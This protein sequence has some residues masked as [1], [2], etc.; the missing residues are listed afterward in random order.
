VVDVFEEVEEQIRTERYMALAKRLAPWAIGAGVALVVSLGGV[1]G[2]QTWHNAQA[3]KAGQIYLDAVEA[4]QNQDEGKAASLFGELTHSPLKIYKV[5]GYMDQAGLR[6]QA[7]K[8]QEAAKLYD[9][10]AAL[11]SDPFV[12]DLARLKSALALM[13]T[14]SYKDIEA[15]LTPLIDDKRPLHLSAREALA[16]AKLQAG[17]TAE[18]RADFNALTLSLGAPEGMVQRARVAMDL[19]DSGSA[20]AMAQA[21]KDSQTINPSQFAPAG[22]QPPEG[23]PQ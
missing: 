14:A 16:F 7:G 18:A 2:Y 22:P 21:V 9:Q 15:R 5:A 3:N 11:A 19:I 4:L 10:A 8:P 6:M 1:W 12:K 23:A 20:A 17:K 13:D